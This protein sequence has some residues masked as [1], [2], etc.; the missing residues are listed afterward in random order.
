M[1][2]MNVQFWRVRVS[3]DRGSQG[4]GPS[5]GRHLERLIVNAQ[6]IESQPNYFLT[7]DNSD[8]SDQ[9]QVLS[10]SIRFDPWLKKIPAQP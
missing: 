9:G 1:T 4:R 5:K 6:V 10:V 8:S 7:T 3:A 2:V